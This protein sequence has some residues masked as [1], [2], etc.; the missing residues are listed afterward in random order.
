MTAK[1][2]ARQAPQ[3]DLQARGLVAKR[4][5]GQNF[6]R[7]SQVLT[8]IVK[9]VGVPASG[10]VVELGAGLGAL[11]RALLEADLKVVA[12]ERDRDLIPVLEELAAQH[13]GR[14][15]VRAEDASHLDY[16]TLKDTYAPDGLTVVGNLPYQLSSRLLVNIAD[17]VP[18]VATAVAM[19]QKEVATRIVAPPGGREYGLLS[20][21][22][23][24]RLSAELVRDVAPTCFYPRPKVTSSVIC[25]RPREGGLRS[26]EDAALV[27]KTARLAFSGRRKMLRRALLSSGGLVKSATLQEVETTLLSADISPQRRAETL[28]VTEFLAMGQALVHARLM[29]IC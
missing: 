22:M 18:C 25:L 20:V 26:H 14:L 13:P 27:G 28:N 8:D 17:A 11:T 29:E 23:Q 3:A 10:W 9:A 2:D 16:A 7:D 21:L 1:F 4:S 24:R 15:V 5:W 6:L 12:I 19:I